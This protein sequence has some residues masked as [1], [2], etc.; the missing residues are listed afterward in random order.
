M[1]RVTDP[2]KLRIPLFDAPDKAQEASR[3]KQA[4]SVFPT[5]KEINGVGMRTKVV[6]LLI[7]YPR[8]KDPYFVYSS[9]HGLRLPFSVA[10]P[11]APEIDRMSRWK[12]N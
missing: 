3:R 10:R 8:G 11:S 7:V 9:A 2:E 12:A 4:I 6:K 1:D 5:I